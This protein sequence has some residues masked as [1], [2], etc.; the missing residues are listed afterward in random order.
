MTPRHMLATVTALLRLSRM[1]EAGLRRR[2]SRLLAIVQ[3][4]TQRHARRMQRHAE[5]IETSDRALE[6][7]WSAL[8][9]GPVTIDRW[10]DIDRQDAIAESIAGAM[11][12]SCRQDDRRAEAAT[13]ACTEVRDGLSQYRKRIAAQETWGNMLRGKLASAREQR[14]EADASDRP[15]HPMDKPTR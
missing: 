10:Q 3:R 6:W 4:S 11:L 8:L 2:E 13:R 14:E 12:E 15:F 1:K 5:H 7:A 9:S